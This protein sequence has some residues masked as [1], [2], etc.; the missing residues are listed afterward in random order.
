MVLTGFSIQV[1]SDQLFSV[2]TK[3]ETKMNKH[4]SYPSGRLLHQLNTSIFAPLVFLV[5]SAAMPLH[6]QECLYGDV[7]RDEV[8]NISDAP[9]WFD[10]ILNQGPYQCEADGRMFWG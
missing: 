6:A 1:I 9:A 2:Q 7:N 8:V 4:Q 3:R 10:L 5:A